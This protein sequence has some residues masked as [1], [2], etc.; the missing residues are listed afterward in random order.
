MYINHICNVSQVFKYILFVDDTNLICCDINLN[1]LVKI[2]TGGL[3]QLETWFSVNV[4]K[5]NYRNYWKWHIYC[6]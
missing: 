2:I 3:E 4:S 5:T 6:R 1:E